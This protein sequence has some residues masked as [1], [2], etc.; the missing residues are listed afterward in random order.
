MTTVRIPADVDRPD[1]LIGQFTARQLAVL[2][3]TALLLYLGWTATRETIAPV[4]YVAGAI[5]IATGV[6]VLILT[7]C[8]GLSADRLLLAAI[9]ARLRP[10]HL[11][12]APDGITAPPRWLTR[13]TR[14]GPKPPAPQPL[15]ASALRLP[16]SVTGSGSGGLGVV[17]LGADGLAVIAAAGTVNLGLRTPDEQDGLVAQLGGWLHTLRQPVQIL[18]RSTRLDLTGQ[19]ADLRDA[20]VEMSPELADAAHAHAEHL[21]GLAA[22]E[23]LMHR[24][25]LLVW[26]EPLDVPSTGD[27]LGGPSPTA[28]LGWLAGGRRRARREL[29]AAARRAAESRLLRR[30][31][32]ATDL[33]A[34]L[35]VT[36][37]PL[38]N[39]QATAVVTG[40]TN[41]GSLVP[42][43][44]D[45]AGPDT[46]ITTESDENPTATDDVAANLHA[47]Q[48]KE[49]VEPRRGFGRGRGRRRGAETGFGPESLSI[50]ARHLEV[51]AGWVATLAV[52]GYPREVMAG[53]LA[54]LLSHPGRL[55]VALHIDPVDPVTAASRLRR[56]LARLESSRIHDASYGRHP[57]PLVEVAAEDA[58]DLS[59]RVARAEA[60][61][62]RVGLYLTVHASS[63][64]E[65]ADEV[66]AVRALAASLLV[67]TCHVTYRP[68]QGWVSTLPLG[69]DLIRVQRS[70]DTTALAAAFPFSS[71]QLPVSDPARA[72]SP[73]GVL[74]GRDAA[75]GLVFV[76]RF[77]PQAHNHNAV[78]LGRSGAGKSYLV[79]TDILR[80]LYRGIEQVI[81][82]PENEYQALTEAVGGTYIHLGTTG[83]RLNPF[84]LEVH[85][86]PDGSRTAPT[87]AVTRRK[88]FCHTVIRVMLGDQTAAQRAT[89]DT[90]V[91]ATYASVGIS[92]NPATWT[93]PAPTLSILCEQ[94]SALGSAVADDLAAALSPFVGEG[95]FAGL[96]DGPTTVSPD[97]GMVAFS[98]RELP[99]EMKTIGTL[100]VLD[101]TW[102]RVSNPANRRPRMVTV[103]EAWLMMRQPAGAEFLF[104][105][106]K[107]FRK[108][109]AGLTVATQDCAD[110]LS[111]ELGK[112]I[113]SNAATQIL[114]HQAP[115]AIDEVAAAFKLSDGE[116]QFLL[117][118]ARGQGLLSLD[119]TDRAV[120]GSLAS[121]REHA[122]VTTNPSEMPGTVGDFGEFGLDVVEAAPN[123]PAVSVVDA[124]TDS[125][126]DHHA[127]VDDEDDGP[128]SF[129]D[130]R[131]A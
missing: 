31:H 56:Q 83:I 47:N 124:D 75:A 43:S 94:L 81:I 32:E 7:T 40:C 28:M 105:A 119:G 117:S 68:V 112:A 41:P 99:D 92:D 38:D 76:D 62:F 126:L 54:P 6:A 22:S 45:I 114:L 37:T 46:I 65:L 106:A 20:T 33:L 69:L 127:D 17:D 74:Y 129:V 13:T 63:Q 61:L 3:V 86:R 59:S 67:D 1:R 80:S 111:T 57:D 121:S 108:N 103:D 29:T 35:G 87:D 34:P 110:V 125:G 98:L 128:G 16:E 36:V 19:L 64:E 23:D 116:R 96:L 66:A 18:L 101:A 102:R 21:A 113:V 79:K 11:V 44:A 131:V 93:R 85:T 48:V 52:T 25:V 24:Q 122:L 89:L 26:R 50:G 55:D 39:D 4:L 123:A 100:L 90:A 95:A 30:V 5:P 115:Q 78:V 51:G 104:R 120:F 77:G 70:F 71:P 109:W 97:T 8:D 10:R 107:S 49:S 12:A 118:A 91:T 15:S 58:A 2:A 73:Q 84:D 53:W 9:R 42:S 72:A 88:L 27:R 82:D 60:R 14:R 130:L